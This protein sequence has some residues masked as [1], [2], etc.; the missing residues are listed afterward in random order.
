MGVILSK[1]YAGTTSRN[2][3]DALKNMRNLRGGNAHS[4]MERFSH[5]NLRKG[6]M[7]VPHPYLSMHTPMEEVEKHMEAQKEDIQEEEV[8]AAEDHGGHA[9]GI[10]T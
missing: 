4:S 3:K 7:E 1:C 5:G 8:E 9:R 6:N 2:G 10:P